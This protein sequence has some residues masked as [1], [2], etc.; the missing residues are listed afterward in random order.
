M[1]C[2]AWLQ[3][4][5]FQLTKSF[6]FRCY[7]CVAPTDYAE[8]LYRK[9]IRH[10]RS[11]IAEEKSETQEDGKDVVMADADNA[12]GWG[13]NAPKRKAHDR[14]SKADVWAEKRWSDNVDH[15]IKLVILPRDKIELEDY[16]AKQ[17]EE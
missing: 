4:L 16:G 15:K 8:E 6:T 5:K 7:Y 1:S 2:R 17:K 11:P 13:R 3:V 9:C 10:L 12:R 14:S